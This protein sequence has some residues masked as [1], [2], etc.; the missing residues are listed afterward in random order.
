M[1]RILTLILMLCLW[2]AAEPVK[3]AHVES[4]LVSDQAVVAPGSTFW[5]AVRLKMD[6][7]WHTYWQYPGDSGLATK[8]DW[9]LPAGVTA[10]PLQWP[11]PEKLAV[12]GLVSFGYSGETYLLTQFQ[13]DPALPPGPLE[14]QA[15][16][17]YLA[18]QESCIPGKADLVLT[19]QSAA[20]SQPSSQAQVLEEARK[21]LPAAAEY[22]PE[23]KL[24]SGSLW[25]T[26]PKGVQ[27]ASFFP[28]SEQQIVL[29]APQTVVD[30][31]LQLKPADPPPARLSGVLATGEGQ[32]YTIDLAPGA[33][34]QSSST[35]PEVASFWSALVLAFLGGMILNLMPCVFPVLSIKILG[36]VEAAGEEKGKPW[37]HGALFTVGVVLSFWALTAA[38]L[39]IKAGGAGVGWGFQQQY[40]PVIVAQGILFFG[41]GLNLLG[42]FEVGLGM[43]RLNDV[44]ERKSGL[45]AA[46]WS[47]VLAT[48]AATPCTAPFMAG[49]IGF[50]LA[51]PAYQT[52]LIFTSLALGMSFPY[53]L[54]SSIPALL[55]FVPRPGPWMESF[56][57]LLAFPMLAAAGA[58]VWVL[59]QQSGVNAMACFIQA[60]VLLGMAGWAYGRWGFSL[61]PAVRLKGLVFAFVVLCAGLGLSWVA[62]Q[63]VPRAGSPGQA[64]AEGGW[65]P[66]SPEKLAELRAAGKPVF[67]DFTAAWCFS[68]Q[69]NDKVALSPA[70]VQQAFKDRGVTLLKADWTRRDDVITRELA[71]F[72]R[73]GVPLYL[74]YPPQGEPEVLPQVLT[75]SIVLKA[76]EKLPLVR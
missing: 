12:S 26:L 9:T 61:K 76:L 58:M 23:L 4:E 20:Q 25:L 3:N 59:G 53:L 24:E 68:C 16:V 18:C 67:V 28:L 51:A 17:S 49:A 48:L 65:Q 33:K 66:Y 73:A 55:R 7:E 1:K 31:A 56:K 39:L 21:R 19:L 74:L 15:N 57:Q 41:V 54:L 37:V 30:E 69:V 45:S 46:F 10:G 44:A 14:I 6:P 5:V 13:T 43:T 75:P 2:A 71:K 8:V 38:L 60:L 62:A 36:F 47:G 40:P 22:G 52:F 32:G 35:A 42:V 29:D 72:G 34:A 64:Q 63:E 11:V 27:S 50:A 70:E